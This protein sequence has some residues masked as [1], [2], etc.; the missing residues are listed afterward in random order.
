ML[1]FGKTGTIA[2]AT[3]NANLGV[4]DIAGLVRGFSL[5]S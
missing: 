3:L 1:L 4:A 2:E 5:V